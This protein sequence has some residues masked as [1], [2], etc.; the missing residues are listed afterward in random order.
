MGKMNRIYEKEVKVLDK[1]ILTMGLF[2][3]NGINITIAGGDKSHIGA[4]SIADEAGNIDTT[5]FPNHK[6]GIIAEAWAKA[7]HE[8]YNQPVVVSAGIHYDNITKDGIE[9]V[10]NTCDSLLDEMCRTM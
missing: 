4:V 7:L 2:T 5:T 3:D 1:N 9:L 8:K 10:V 6:E